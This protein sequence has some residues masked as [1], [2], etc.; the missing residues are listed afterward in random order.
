MPRI[1]LKINNESDEIALSDKISCYVVDSKL[2]AAKIATTVKSGKMV[3]AQ[4]KEAINCVQK[5]NLDGVLIEVDTSKPI[6][7]Q[8]K[9]LRNQLAKKTLGVIIPPRR[10]EAMLASEI[11]PEFVVFKIDD[12][13]VSASFLS[14]YNELFLLPFA[15]QFDRNIPP[16]EHMNTDFVIVSAEKFKDSS[17]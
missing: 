9:P 3:L 5:Y 1:I 16:L 13:S 7:S 17:C 14:W 6:K 8:L 15:L 11:E 10:H 12:L 2:G 4:G